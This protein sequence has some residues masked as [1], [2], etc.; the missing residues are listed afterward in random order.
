MYYT[1]MF[2]VQLHINLGFIMCRIYRTF[3]LA[4]NGIYVIALIYRL[5]KKKYDLYVHQFTLQSFH[6]LTCTCDNFDW[7]TS[8]AQYEKSVLVNYLYVSWRPQELV[9]LLHARPR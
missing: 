5:I 8:N 1:M 9:Y 3:V 4:S 6:N 2:Q 7:T